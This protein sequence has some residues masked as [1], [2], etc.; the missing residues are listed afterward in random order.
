MQW[1]GWPTADP[2]RTTDLMPGLV[3]AKRLLDGMTSSRRRPGSLVVQSFRHRS[4]AGLWTL[5]AGVMPRR[6]SRYEHAFELVYIVATI[7]STIDWAQAS[8]R[9]AVDRP[10]ERNAKMSAADA[11][12]VGTGLAFVVMP[13]VFVFAFATHPDLLRPRVLR[14]EQLVDRSWGRWLAL[15]CLTWQTR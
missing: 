13:L 2:F 7:G 1:R 8:A 9:L 12:R 14:P 11:A 5:E 6:D 4:G 15:A 3:V 10:R